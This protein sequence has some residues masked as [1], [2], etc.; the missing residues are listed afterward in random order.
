MLATRSPDFSLLRKTLSFILGLFSS[1]IFGITLMACTAGYIAIGSGIPKVREAFE[2]NE[3]QFFN[4]WPL[5]TLMALL[6]ANLCVVTW[7]RIPLTP[8]RY[9]VW[10]VHLGIIT[11]I[12]GTSFYYR[13]KTEGLTRIPVGQ[14]IDYYY[15][16][17][18]RA[19]YARVDGRL[20]TPWRLPSL[21]RF[22]AYPDRDDS[23]FKHWDLQG[24]IPYFLTMDP[25]T[26][27]PKPESLA[28]E[29][30]VKDV[31]FD[32]TGYWPYAEVR[33]DY[34]EDPAS[35]LS[36]IAVHL[37]DAHGGTAT[38]TAWL[39][40]SDPTA[41]SQ[42]LGGV[43]LE[44][45][46]A[47]DAAEVAAIKKS[48]G[49]LHRIDV[50]LNG[51]SQRMFV[52]VGG[53]YEISGTGYSFTVESFNPA[54]PMSG[55]G[56]IVQALTLHV[57]AKSPATPR[58][59]RRMILGGK[60]LQTDFALNVAGAGPM[61][62]RQKEPLDKDLVLLYTLSDPYQ[63]LPLQGREKHTLVTSS[64]AGADN[65]IID[66][67][68]GPGEATTVHDLPATGGQISIAPADDDATHTPFSL[69]VER[70]DHLRRDE[71]VV[72]VPSAQRDRD[73]GQAGIFQ[74]LRVKVVSGNWSKEVLVPYSQY[75]AEDTWND[76]AVQ[77]GR[78]VARS[79]N[80]DIPGA[81]A[82][83][84]LRLGQEYEW[85]P[86]R[87]TLERFDAVP[88]AGM[89]S[90]GSSLMRDFCSTLT[91]E[92]HHTGEKTT[93]VAHMNHPVYFG[94]GS[95]LFFQAQWD[96]DGQRW[97]ILGVGNRPGIDVMITGCVMIVLGVLYAFYV[98]PIVIRRMK[99]KALAKASQRIESKL[100]VPAEVGV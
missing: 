1:V 61:G 47:A 88:Y 72:E 31:S 9:G 4:A 95:W 23:V 44:N 46:I 33:T 77:D 5:K 13:N 41:K 20:T 21:P 96:P 36:G 69:S 65:G 68:A 14:S 73:T 15:D 99:Q 59:Y 64:A 75:V 81:H 37:D 82:S 16:G 43:E 51:H 90:S 48:A 18:I 93:D 91:I 27:D 67:A 80:I 86:A 17:G 52:D 38:P 2:M 58:E 25:N 49:E 53:T 35:N 22:K 34:V 45:R 66:I 97:T 12:L 79:T 39:V 42:D 89:G 98:K 83:L 60:P 63:L 50:N 87:L 30:G 11:L 92:D 3:L 78:T 28:S 7:R 10:C 24:F 74:V 85:L 62:K 94:G 40:G 84:Q 19:I 76:S 6:V 100:E 57:M 70:Q 71:H 26:G 32:I 8:P 29:L 54:F 56:E 55:T